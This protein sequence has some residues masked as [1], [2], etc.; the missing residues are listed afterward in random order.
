MWNSE[1]L[2][3]SKDVK[4]NNHNLSKVVINIERKFKG[5][6]A[7]WNHVNGYTLIGY[8]VYRVANSQGW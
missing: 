6:A 1:K 2:I 5:Q 8:V 3:V 4:Y 7:H